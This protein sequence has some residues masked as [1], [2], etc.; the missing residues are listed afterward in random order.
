MDVACIDV[1][2]VS[3]CLSVCCATVG[4]VFVAKVNLSDTVV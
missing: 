1:N 4:R 2:C 3:L